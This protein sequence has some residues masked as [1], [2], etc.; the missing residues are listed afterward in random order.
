MFQRAGSVERT[1]IDVS[2]SAVLK[3]VEA[4]SAS[5]EVISAL[6]SASSV[7]TFK[8]ESTTT[9]F[10]ELSWTYK[11]QPNQKTINREKMM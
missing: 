7:L 8:L 5:F 4:S 1:E 11:F 2:A 9:D 6:P 10:Q 3:T